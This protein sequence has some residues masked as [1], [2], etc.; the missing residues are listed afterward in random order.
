LAT[1]RQPL[2]TLVQVSRQAAR[3]CPGLQALLPTSDPCERL[4]Q[5][6]I[7]EGTKAHLRNLVIT[8]DPLKLPEEIRAMQAHLIAFADGETPPSMTPAAPDL[9]AF[10]ASLL[11]RGGPVRSVRCSRQRPNRAI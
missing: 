11:A 2:P 10:I 6:Q 9:G 3:G 5:A 8:L 7:P 1:V 4:L